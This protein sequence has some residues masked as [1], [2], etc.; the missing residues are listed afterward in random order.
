M[1][2]ERQLRASRSTSGGR[3]PVDLHVPGHHR[4]RRAHRDVL[5]S[6]TWRTRTVPS[7]AALLHLH[8]RLHLLDAAARPR[9][10]TSSF[11]I[12]GWAPVGLSS[13]LLIGFWYQ[14]RSAVVAARKAF[15][16][17]VIGDVRHDPGHLRAVRAVPPVTYSGD[18]RTLGLDTG[19]LPTATD[20]LAPSLELA[21]FLLC[22]SARWPSRPSSPPHLAAGRHGGPHPRQRTRS[23]PPRWCTA[24]VYL[25]GAM[26]PI[27]DIAHLRARRGGDRRRQST[28]LFA[29]TIAIVQADIKRGARLPRR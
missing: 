25:V 27:Y 4:R 1:D 10:A 7:Y 16:M 11:L 5:R 6:A 9:R 26:H 18:A 13:Y 24:G 23:T 22:W 21:A 8:G 3:Q 2:Q 19:C 17:N 15:V 28:A 12:V 14:R 20:R 29:A